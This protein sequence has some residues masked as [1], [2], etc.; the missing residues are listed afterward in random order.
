VT[1]CNEICKKY[2]VTKIPRGIG[3]YQ[4]GQKL[5][6]YCGIFIKFNGSQCPCCN[7]RLRIKRRSTK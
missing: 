3:R 2:I 1:L 7:T 4:S 5:C 6:R